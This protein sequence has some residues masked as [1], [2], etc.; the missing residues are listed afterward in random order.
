MKETILLGTSVGIKCNLEL[1]E[2]GEL[3]SEKVFAGIKFGGLNEHIHEEI[4]AIYIDE[5][6]LGFQII[7]D[8]YKD[9]YYTLYFGVY[10]R[11]VRMNNRSK[12]KF[13]NNEFREYL[14]HVLSQIPELEI[15]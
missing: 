13:I 12:Y 11:T 9:E 1:I 8:G 2:L 4:P 10:P 5:P 7:L 14:K 6:V 3:L 15:M